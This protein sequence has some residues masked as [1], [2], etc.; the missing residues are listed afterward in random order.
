LRLTTLLLSASIILYSQTGSNTGIAGTIVDPS[1]AS[2]AGA[3]VKIVR[4]G[5]GDA[6]STVTGESGKFDVRYLAAGSHQIEV[7]SP[8]FRRLVRDG[9]NVTTAR[10]MQGGPRVIQFALK[11][12]F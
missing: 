5:T 2:V 11:L 10:V 1:G 7:E 8:K 9:V 6:R 4:A 3:A 12:Q